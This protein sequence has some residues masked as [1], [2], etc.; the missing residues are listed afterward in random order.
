MAKPRH[1]KPENA[2]PAVRPRARDAGRG[3]R[4]GGVPPQARMRLRPSAAEKQDSP[5]VP[6]RLTRPLMSDWSRAE[7]YSSSTA[8]GAPR[9]SQATG[10]IGER[11]EYPA[12][13][14]DVMAH[15][16]REP[17]HLHVADVETVRAQLRDLAS[18]PVAEVYAASAPVQEKP[19]SSASGR[20]PGDSIASTASRGRRTTVPRERTRTEPPPH[21]SETRP[22]KHGSPEIDNTDPRWLRR[23]ITPVQTTVRGCWGLVHDLTWMFLNHRP[24]GVRPCLRQAMVTLSSR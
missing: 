15:E 11:N 2:R 9:N 16:R 12:E 3:R 21:P 17:D 6:S 8:A 18:P 19:S 24:R 22:P 13:H 14:A 10:E 23:T 4:A 5:T 20:S 1:H 7:P